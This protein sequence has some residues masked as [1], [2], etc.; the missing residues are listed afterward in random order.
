MAISD[1]QTDKPECGHPK[2]AEL[3]DVNIDTGAQSIN[4]ERF[5]RMLFIVP[6][7][8][9]NLCWFAYI[10]SP[11]STWSFFWRY[12]AGMGRSISTIRGLEALADYIIALHVNFRRFQ[13]ILV[14]SSPP[15]SVSQIPH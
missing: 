14:H 15:P 11:L 5:L 3:P 7:V 6:E 9:S 8:K 2:R 13:S 12:W 4:T 10:S 1:S